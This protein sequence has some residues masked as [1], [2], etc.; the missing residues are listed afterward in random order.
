M[1][2]QLFT[3]LI[4]LVFS[5]LMVAVSSTAFAQNVQYDTLTYPEPETYVG[6]GYQNGMGVNIFI[7][8]YGFG[9]GGQYRHMVG[10]L[11]ELTVSLDISG[12]RDVSE[13]TLQ[14]WTGQQVVP[15]KYQRVFAF[16]LRF[17][18][19]HRVFAERIASNTRFYLTVS[20]G[21]SMAITIPYFN[22][23]NNN[24]VRDQLR[25]NSGAIYNERVND[26]FRG[27]KNAETEFGLSGDILLSVDFGE[28]FSKLQTIQFGFYAFYYGQGLQIMEPKRYP[29]NFDSYEQINEYEDNVD[30]FGKE[31]YFGTPYISLIFGKFWK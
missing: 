22:D 2:Q 17:G 23:K 31:K 25:F 15:N 20:A 30:F 12:I 13:Q 11:T 29:D 26:I 27:W 9:L 1:K 7:N 18:V 4:A 3:G 16:P 10:P 28:N 19:R 24:G 8:N 14:Y 5:V 21:P 6:K